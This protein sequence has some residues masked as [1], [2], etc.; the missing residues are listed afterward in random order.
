[1]FTIQNDAS[2]SP[3]AEARS[4]Y[5][6]ASALR[7]LE[8]LL[9]FTEEP[10]EFGLADV[11]LRTGL[12][13]NQ[14]YRSLKTLEAAGFLAQTPEGRYYLTPLVHALSASVARTSR[15]SLVTL[16]G[17]ILD[18]L[19]AATGESVHLGALIGDHVVMI[20]RRES[21][22]RVRLSSAELGQSLT[23]HAGAIP[24]AVLSVAPAALVEA[25]LDAV[26]TLPRL[27]PVTPT[28]RADLA[29]ELAATRLRGYSLSDGDFDAAARG[30]GAPIIDASGA[31]IG[32][33]SAGGPRFRISDADLERFGALVVDAARDLSRR[34]GAAQPSRPLLGPLYPPLPPVP[35]LEEKA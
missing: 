9:A 12:E 1:M 4:P 17:P 10:Y 23:L 28:S 34:L 16:A 20:D 3:S 35:P 15:A 22:H 27:G 5:V 29:A 24:K 32:G 2:P 18:R 31:V 6:I 25:V 19:A 13:R 26:D 21:V 30:V 8:L 11:I 33:I 7:T 14:A